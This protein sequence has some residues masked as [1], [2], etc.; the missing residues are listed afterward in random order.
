MTCSGCTELAQR[1]RRWGFP[2]SAAF[3]P[4]G[5]PTLHPTATTLMPV[6][7]DH[8]GQASPMPAPS[9][10][11][12]P[13]VASKDI[14]CVCSWIERS[15]GPPRRSTDR[16]R[17]SGWDRAARHVRQE[18]D[19]TGV[20]P[21]RCGGPF[22][23]RFRAC[24][25]RSQGRGSATHRRL[26]PWT[27]CHEREAGRVLKAVLAI[28]EYPSTVTIPRVPGISSRDNLRRRHDLPSSWGMPMHT[29][30]RPRQDCWHTDHC[31]TSPLLNPGCI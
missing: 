17:Q 22:P 2:S 12:H 4:G 8:K 31:G 5:R 26:L 13:P 18:I 24:R 28:Y 6:R 27:E 10:T 20:C 14:S 11:L 21:S 1:S 25:K 30:S 16:V 23:R 19:R 29:F 9:S 15:A 3:L 7:P